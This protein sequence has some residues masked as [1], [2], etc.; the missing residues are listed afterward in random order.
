M[1]LTMSVSAWAK[2]YC[3]ELISNG[4]K[5]IYMTCSPT[6][7]AN[8]YQILFEGTDEVKIT[9]VNNANVGINDIN[10][11]P[12]GNALNFAVDPAGNGS[13]KATFTK[14]GTPAAPYVAALFFAT[15]VGEVAFNPFPTDMDWAACSPSAPESEYCSYVGTTTTSLQAGAHQ[16]ALTIVTDANGDVIVTI[17]DATNGTNCRWRGDKGIGSI[18]QF[19]VNEEAAS[20]YFT[21]AKIDDH[22][23]KFT[24]TAELPADAVLKKFDGAIE[25]QTNEFYDEYNWGRFEYT[26][27]SVCPTD[28]PVS[29]V[30]LDKTTASVPANKTLTLTAS[31]AP[32]NAADKSVTWLSSKPEVATVADGVVTPVAE[33][34]TTITVKTNDGDHTATCEVT[35]NPAL[36]TEPTAA[37][38]APAYTADKVKAVYSAT[39]G[40]DCDFGEWGSGTTYQQ[41]TYGKKYTVGNGYFGITFEGAKALNCATM[42]FLHLDVWAADEMTIRIVPIHTGCNDQMGVTKTLTAAQWNSFNIPLGDFNNGNDW[43]NVYQIKIDQVAGHPTLWINNIY[44][45]TTSDA[46]VTKPV[47]TLATLESVSFTSAIINVAATDDRGVTKYVVKNGATEVGKFVPADGKITVTGLTDGTAYTLSIYAQ[48]GAENVS[49]NKIDVELTTLAL[50]DAAPAP[51][52]TN[53]DYVSVYAPSLTNM[54]AHDFVLSNWGSA[55]GT[56]MA[57]KGYIFYHTANNVNVVWGENNAG[58]N[59]IVAADGYKGDKGGLDASAMEYMHVDI[60]ADAPCNSLVLV[61]NDKNIGAAQNLT[62]GWNHLDVSLASFPTNPAEWAHGYGLNNVAW[63]K[64][65]GLNNTHDVAITNVYFWKAS[66]DAPKQVIATVNDP[67][68]GT[69]VVKQGDEVVTEVENGTNADFIAEANDGYLFLGWYNGAELVS[70]NATHTVENIQ[71]K[72]TLEARFRA[73]NNIYCHTELKT[74]D[75]AHTIYLTMKKSGNDYQIVIDSEE[76]M[77]GFGGAY[78]GGY[79]ESGDHQIQLNT[80]ENMAKFVTISDNKHRITINVTSTTPLRWN[81]PIYMRYDGHAGDYAFTAPQ[82]KTVEYDVTCAPVA[83]ESV[84]LNQTE[85]TVDVEGTVTLTAA[86]SPIYADN[87]TV[88][89]TSNKETVAT[90][91]NGVVTGHA[92]GDA[93]ITATIDGKSAICAITV[94]LDPTVPHVAAPAVDATGKE[95]RAIYSDDVVLA[96][97]NADFRIN[98]YGNVPS[99]QK[100]IEG[101]NYWLCTATPGNVVLSWGNG[102]GWEGA[103][104]GKAGMTNPEND[105]DKGL[106]AVGMK[107]LHIDIWSS[108]AAAN[109]QI[110]NDNNIICMVDLD[111]SGWQSFDIDMTGKENLLKNISIIKFLNT[112]TNTKVAL[113]NLYFWKGNA[114]VTGVSLNKTATTLDAGMKETLVATIAPAN[115]ANQNVT[116]ESDNAEV[117]TVDEYGK[118]TAVAEGEATITVTTVDGGF[119]ATCT[120]TVV[121][122]TTKT[123]YGYA[124]KNGIGFEYALT[125]NLDHTVTI[126]ITR[127]GTKTG[128]VAPSFSIDGEWKDCVKDGDVWTRT[129]TKTFEAGATYDCFIQNNYAG[130]QSDPHFSYTIGSENE[131]PVIEVTGVQIAQETL[132]LAIDETYTLTAS[133]L[134]LAATVKTITWSSDNTDVATVDAATGLVT[135]KAAGEANITATSTNGKTATCVVTVVAA[136]EPATW[137]CAGVDHNHNI[138]LKYNIVRTIDRTLTFSATFEGADAAVQVSIAGVYNNLTNNDG[139]W[140]WTSTDTYADGATVTGFF[141]MPF[142]GGAGRVDFTYTVGSENE[143][144]NVLV[145]KTLYAS[146]TEAAAAAQNNKPIEVLADITLA[147]AQKLGSKDE[148]ARTYTLNLNGKTVTGKGSTTMFTIYDN[149][150]LTNGNLDYY[151][152][153]IMAYAINAYGNVTIDGVNITDKKNNAGNMLKA[154]ANAT[155]TLKSG[156][157]SSDKTRGGLVSVAKDATFVMD[158]GEL[159]SNCSTNNS[160]YACVN[161]AT[162]GTANVNDGTL[163]AAAIAV[164]VDGTANIAGGELNAPTSVW[165]NKGTVDITDGTFVAPATTIYLYTET[166][167]AY[168]HGGEFMATGEDKRYLVNILDAVHQAALVS[169]DG[170]TFYGFNPADNIA[171]GAHT[172]FCAEG[173]TG[174]NTND[175]VF[176]VLPI[177]PIRDGLTVGKMG[178]ICYGYDL[179]EVKGAIF[180]KPVAYDGFYLHFVEVDEV[181]AGYGY[182]F[183]AEAEEITAVKLGDVELTS[184]ITGAPNHMQGILADDDNNLPE[185][186]DYCGIKNGHWQFFGANNTMTAEH[187]YIVLPGLPTEEP[188]GANPGRRHLVVSSAD[189]TAVVTGL[190]F[191]DLDTEVATKVLRDGQLYIIREGKMYNVQGAVVK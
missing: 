79:S 170:G 59:A 143:D 61:V 102:N 44:F 19:K 184:A 118:V 122:P 173:Y 68:M 10:G 141:Y 172:N 96:I 21:L 83:V 169:I 181:L 186:R 81:T 132:E 133:V 140:S 101:N 34:T 33:G 185:G 183:V 147:G 179:A 168:I 138:I 50:P 29:G 129:T 24:K 128:I 149:V 151:G 17:S 90:V 131:K 89:W 37:P 52:V 165:V 20:N 146:I 162:G 158:G 175:N 36:P 134:P 137:Y 86:A 130:G 45:Y 6:D 160:A 69:A 124:E 91:V 176:E 18:D 103:L 32:L 35:V 15:N 42:E 3:H 167:K 70:T 182:M 189:N 64:F 125:Y 116:W 1:M 127:Y 148:T 8:E 135:A 156:V 47:M 51:V 73:L 187:A 49:D 78:L 31:V 119:T 157:I 13:A 180:Y 4:S 109:F 58:G 40:A 43:S 62:A 71:A 174:V 88:T 111:G 166:A 53:K 30:T 2:S 92:E 163:T 74:G 104:L 171:E 66:A 12:G 23:C 106:Y 9:G 14:E 145:D 46:D 154:N 161:V 112:P 95:I 98:A 39:Y 142:T 63:L 7:N 136:L 22:T 54:L 80:A 105:G 108:E 11:H 113:D 28:I 152:M 188:Q 72:T 159:I 110:C 115:A 48:D 190:D 27:G 121:A 155:L 75:E 5:S 144:G 25:F 99:V 126:V 107:Y 191:S 139:V 57:D 100:A 94:A 97:T 41:D 177:E 120:V 93:T 77:T 65:N 82:N 56:K 87:Q 178:T 38:E 26:Y 153:G 55:A 76:K 114:A 164:W 16:F 84:T 123:W 117:A 85:A 150:T 67:A 60:W